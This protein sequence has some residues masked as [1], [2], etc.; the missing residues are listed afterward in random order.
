MLFGDSPVTRGHALDPLQSAVGPLAS[1]SSRAT[2]IA[3]G[4][5]SDDTLSPVFGEVLL[6]SGYFSQVALHRTMILNP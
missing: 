4:G 3:V 6:N 2:K 1:L 5:R